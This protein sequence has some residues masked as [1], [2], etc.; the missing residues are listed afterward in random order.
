MYFGTW[1]FAT[2]DVRAI[3]TVSLLYPFNCFPCYAALEIVC[4]IIINSKALLLLLFIFLP[5]VLRSRGS[6]KI[7]YEI[8]RWV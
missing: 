4:V 7:N 1:S 8:Q 3:D 6:L 2:V 5:S